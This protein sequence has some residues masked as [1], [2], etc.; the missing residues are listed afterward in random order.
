MELPCRKQDLIDH[1]D[2]ATDLMIPV[3]LISIIHGYMHK[4][5]VRYID[6]SKY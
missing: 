4:S 6:W 5:L 2:Q 3:P 1:F